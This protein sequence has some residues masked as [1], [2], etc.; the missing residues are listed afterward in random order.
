VA[1]HKAYITG[2]S[3]EEAHALLTENGPPNLVYRHNAA[4]V[5]STVILWFGVIATFARLVLCFSI[6]PFHY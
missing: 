5:A 3:Q 1:S 4:A 2:V 6:I